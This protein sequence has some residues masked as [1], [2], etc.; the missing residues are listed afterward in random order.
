MKRK[1][2]ECKECNNERQIYAR[3]L[4]GFCYQKDRA[5]A[6]QKRQKNKPKK[7]KAISPISDKQAE[8]LKVYRKNRDKYMKEHPFCEAR[9]ENCTFKATDLHHK[10][11]RIGDNLTNQ[12]Y[13]M[14]LCRS[15]HNFI[16][17]KM[18]I[19]EAERKGLRIRS[20]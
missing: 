19:E 15:C 2:K 9:L 20:L 18:S 10:K 8:R 13:F 4:C 14:A 11:K 1:V 12:K 7:R 3:G 5:K 16:E 6:Y 17:N